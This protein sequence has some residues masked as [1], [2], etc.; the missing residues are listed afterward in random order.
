MGDDNGVRATGR[1]NCGAVRFEIRGPMRDIIACHCAECRRMSGH[2]TAATATRPQH[3]VMLEDEGLRWYRS[4]ETAERGFCQVCGSTL[5]WK[6]ASGDRVSVY[7][8]CLNDTGGLPLVAHIFV[9]EKG[10]YYAV[11]AV[12]GVTVHPASSGTL[13]AF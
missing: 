2:Y 6:P 3:L 1:C 10:D 13:A 4:S 7:A 8:G 12:D 5:F 11:E 9:A